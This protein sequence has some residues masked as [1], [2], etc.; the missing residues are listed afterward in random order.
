ML[1]LIIFGPPGS[2]KGTQA[3]KLERKY[4]LVHISTGDI[5]RSEIAEGSELGVQ[6]SA[7]MA[8]GELVP[9]EVTI[10]MLRKKMMAHKGADGFI[11]DG[12]PRTAPQAEALESLLGMMDTQIDALIMLDVPEDEIVKRIV[13]RSAESR[14]ADDSDESIIRNRFQVYQEQTEPIYTFYHAKGRAHKI[15]G[16]GSIDDIFQKLCDV[17]SSIHV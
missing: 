2:G 7:F 15:H 3:K 10:G 13:L 4:N 16:M 8:K 12:F 14:R 17:I 6:A 1:N 5:F 11:F 9:D